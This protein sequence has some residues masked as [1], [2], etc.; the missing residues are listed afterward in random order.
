MWH[1]IFVF[2]ISFLT[3]QGSFSTKSNSALTLPIH[4]LYKK[5]FWLRQ[6]IILANVLTCSYNTCKW[7]YTALRGISLLFCVIRI[8]VLLHI[9]CYL[10]QMGFFTM[11]KQQGVKLLKRDKALDDV[12][13]WVSVSVSS[14]SA[15]LYLSS[16]EIFSCLLHS[17][18]PGEATRF[19]DPSLLLAR[20]GD[21]HCRVTFPDGF[22]LSPRASAWIAANPTWCVLLFGVYLNTNKVKH[23]EKSKKV[24]KRPY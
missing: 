5:S 10:M 4:G 20:V 16:G 13:K 15:L 14:T 23:C 11:S 18:G 6:H 3:V 1:Q 7:T 2:T 9:L 19:N 12:H 17:E 21:M 8:L 22:T 24:I